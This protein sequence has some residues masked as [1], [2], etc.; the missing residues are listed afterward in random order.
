MEY[1]VAKEKAIRYIGISKK[2]EYEVT[3]K[4][5]SLGADSLTISKIIDELIGLSY[6][7]DEQYIEAYI[8]QNMR[9]EKYSIYELKQKLLQKGLKADIIDLKFNKCISTAYENKVIS[10][11]LSSKLKGYDLTKKKSYLYRRAF[12]K[13]SVES[14][15]DDN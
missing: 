1:V 7:D 8:R 12:K 4:L 9:T 5:K 11:L 3:K 13:E 6:I 14:T 15:M 2:T 10:K